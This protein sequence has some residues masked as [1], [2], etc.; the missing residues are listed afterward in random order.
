[1]ERKNLKDDQ[2]EEW[3]ESPVTEYF[4]SLV[5][6][7]KD[8][9][10]DAL[11]DQGFDTGSASQLM[12]QRGN[13]YGIYNTF[14]DLEGVFKSQSFEELEEEDEQLRDIPGR[15]QGSDQAGLA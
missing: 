15:G 10:R 3:F 14:E 11:A 13:L 6:R 8:E 7:L 5:S 4:F 12:A 9:T 1:M 2:I